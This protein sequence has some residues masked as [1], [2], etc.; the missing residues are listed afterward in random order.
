[1]SIPTITTPRLVLRPF[2]DDDAPALHQILSVPG[3][4]R[5]FPNTQP[6]PLEKVHKLVSHQLQ[7][8]H[9]HNLGW[10]AVEPRQEKVFIGWCGLQYL[11]ETDETEVA[12]LLAKPYWG[13]GLATEGARASLRYGFETLELEIIIGLVHPENIASQRVI[14]KLGMPFTNEARYFGIDVYRYA[15]NR[16]DFKPESTH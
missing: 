4:L 3:V 12:Y 8:W 11:P 1:M 13:Q 9:E 14:E 5:Y 6:P 15:L 7:H 10:W 2:A 16:S